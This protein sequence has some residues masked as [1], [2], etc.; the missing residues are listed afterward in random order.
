M[1]LFKAAAVCF[2][3]N[4]YA[5]T[6]CMCSC[7]RMLDILAWGQQHCILT[8]LESSPSR[9]YNLDVP[10]R[11]TRLTD[12]DGIERRCYPLLAFWIADRKAANALLNIKH[13][14]A[15]YSDPWD[16]VHRES[17]DKYNQTFEPR[18]EAAMKQ[19]SLRIHAG[20]I[21]VQVVPA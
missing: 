8:W 15:S 3:Q 5:L 16:L 9:N 18:T 20:T 14:P 11:G 7:Q 12:A 21:E 10:C 19:V 6:P 1:V 13:H 17:L 2:W 4:E